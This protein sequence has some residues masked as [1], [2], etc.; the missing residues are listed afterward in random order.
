MVFDPEVLDQAFDGRG[1]AAFLGVSENTLRRMRENGVI[2]AF[3]IPSST[4]GARH[5]W[6]YRCLDLHEFVRAN[7]N[8][9][10]GSIPRIEFSVQAIARLVGVSP[11]DIRIQKWRGRL[12][13]YDPVSVRDYLV[14]TSRKSVV[15]EIRQEFRAQLFRLRGEIRRL[16]RQ[17]N[18]GKNGEDLQQ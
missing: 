4:R 8:L 18:I 7:G 11:Q 5:V 15:R 10:R 6:R 1:A 13:G 9:V 12:K 16:R 17:L 14:T 2:P 3:Q